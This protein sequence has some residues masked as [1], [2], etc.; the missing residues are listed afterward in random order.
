[1]TLLAM[2]A[3]AAL[4]S[5]A[6]FDRQLNLNGRLLLNLCLIGG[7]AALIV[8][9][10]ISLIIHLSFTQLEEA[11]AR[12]QEARADAY[13]EDLQDNI[14]L[15][16]RDWGIWDDSHSYINNFN[17]EFVESNI[18]PESF[19]NAGIEGLAFVRFDGSGASTAYF[20]ADGEPRPD[21]AAA[22]QQIVTASAFRKLAIPGKD[23][24]SFIIFD[25]RLFVLGGT[26]ILPSSLAGPSRGY[27][28]FFQPVAIADFNKALQ[29]RGK[30]S[31]G[32][33]NSEK[34]IARDG[35]N[36]RITLP[37]EAHD[38]A[39]VGSV[40]FDVRRDLMAVGDRLQIALIIAL[41]MVGAA[42]L[43]TLRWR[44]SDL[45]VQPVSALSRNVSRIR[46]TGHL[47]T[48]T[49]V[50]GAK[51]IVEL[52]DEFNALFRELESLRAENED[53]SFEL[54]R[55]QAAVG[56]M[57]NVR[58]SLSP[59]KVILG[60]LIDQVGKVIPQNFERALIELGDDR[61]PADRRERLI[62]YIAATREDI[63]H[64]L[65]EIGGYA[66]QANHNLAETLA[67]IA[68]NQEHQR[69]ARM[70]ERFNARIVLRDATNIATFK[71]DTRI[72]VVLDCPEELPACGNRLLLR[73][74]LENLITNSTEAIV[75]SGREGGSVSIRA[76]LS[77]DKQH[78]VITIRDDGEGFP[79]E[80]A[81]Q[82]FESGFSTRPEKV[83]GLGLHWC[84][85]TINAM[86][87]SI[88]LRSDGRG[89]GATATVTLQTLPAE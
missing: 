9:M 85:N 72:G 18:N 73:Q 55:S 59:I 67:V 51:E 82:L 4:D 54:G 10:A 83:G 50:G 2:R 15:R 24:H 44:I 80:I 22:F 77:D 41:L 5:F 16:A 79:A 48:M 57:H 17:S 43:V 27:V 8:L 60:L 31:L 26:S 36:L 62:A 42:M 71:A 21:L 56:V 47:A 33:A 45:I 19:R 74:V 35:S 89:R 38:Q 84:A 69:P 78:C 66:H 6:R 63:F 88:A 30:L 14:V 58:N 29:V 12:R 49:S 52:Q 20:D 61:T 32:G 75:A 53:Q 76:R 1:M 68:G 70:D 23:F 3:R 37:I 34:V 64:V 28:V 13:F 65:D 46:K 81:D 86:G 25:R 39:I 7:T 87:G 11:D 40:S